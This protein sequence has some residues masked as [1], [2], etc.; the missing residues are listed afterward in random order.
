MLFRSQHIVSPDDRTKRLLPT[1][2]TK[3]ICVA[4]TTIKISYTC[5]GLLLEETADLNQIKEEFKKAILSV[6]DEAKNSNILRYNRVRP[7]LSTL[8]GVKDFEEFRIN[9]GTENI[10]LQQEEYPETG[11]LIFTIGSSET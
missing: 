8:H 6:Y 2:C 4:A 5:T 10:I 3:L 11:T 1:A 9:G 7:L